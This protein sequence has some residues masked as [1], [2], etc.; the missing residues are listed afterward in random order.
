[1]DQDDVI[2][3]LRALRGDPIDETVA[4]GHLDR[5]AAA[6]RRGQRRWA[7][8]VAAGLIAIGVPAAARVVGGGPDP[9]GASQTGDEFG[10]LTCAGPPPFA[11]VPATLADPDGGNVPSLRAAIP[12]RR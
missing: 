3:R 6:A 7:T 10:P 11:G 9:V 8:L 2:G 12:G 1:M 5:A 4:V